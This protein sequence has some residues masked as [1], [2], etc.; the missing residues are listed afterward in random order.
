[1]TEGLDKIIDFLFQFL[2][3]LLPFEVI[4]YYNRG[5]R[6]RLGKP[7]GGVLDPGLHWKVPFADDILTHMVKT[8]TIN[9]L[10]QT[11]TTKDYKSIVV[12]AVIKY[13][14]SDVS[15]LLL[16]V[17]DPTDALADMVQG[18]IRDKLIE[19][20][21]IECNSPNLIGEI[22]RKAKAEAKQWGISIIQITLTDLAE[23]RSIRLL[24]K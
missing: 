4:P 6:L 5:V 3:Q 13:E 18:I 24:N 11:I 23:M 14:V 21:W 10:E 9:L 17:N 2:G 19:K 8:K 20:D 16:E 12:K 1:M 15:T 22:S 7:V